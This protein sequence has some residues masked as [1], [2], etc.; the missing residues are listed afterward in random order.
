[1]GGIQYLIEHSSPSDVVLDVGSKSGEDMEKLS[2]ETVAVDITFRRTDRDTDYIVADGTNLPFRSNSFDYVLCNQVLEHVADTEGMIEEISRVLDPDG[3]A[4]FNFPNRLAP[5][6]PHSPPWWYS[7]LP[8]AVGNRLADSLLDE[9]TA[10]YYRTSEYMLTPMTARWLLHKHFHS[11]RYC[12][13]EYKNT[14]DDEIKNG[15]K[16]FRHRI[17]FYVSPLFSHVE[18]VPVVGWLIELVYS[19]V[20]Y[21]CSN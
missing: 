10:E 3:E 17:L 7:Y 19:H 13:F 11:V 14:Y 21:V 2:C 6:S 15:L 18:S 5:T 8:R 20:A 4:I 9:A 12:T 1:M 16:S